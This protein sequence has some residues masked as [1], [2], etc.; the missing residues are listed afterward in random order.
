ML[1]L[2][3]VTLVGF[4][5]MQ[6]GDLRRSIDICRQH[7]KFRNTVIFTDEPQWFDCEC[8]LI[9]Q[10]KCY[11]E[12]SVHSI[13]TI[14]RY[15]HLYGDFILTVH[16]DSWIVNPDAWKEQFLDYDFIGAPW[17]N[18]IVG[19]DGFS[20]RSQKL[21]RCL[22]ELPIEPT[23]EACHPADCVTCLEQCDSRTKCFRKELEAQGVTYAP[24]ELAHQ[25]SIENE[26]YAG[27]F[28]FH[29]KYTLRDIMI[30]EYGTPDPLKFRLRR[31]HTSV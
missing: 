20:I 29:G 16:S 26:F 19:N 12:V 23:P 9:P 22:A 21:L 11:E 30:R 27:S 6:Y 7:A 8:V 17:P 13:H 14:P 15:Q 24:Y 3:N 10:M 25:F 31:I 5:T 18:K 28:G 1:D 4:T 2:Q